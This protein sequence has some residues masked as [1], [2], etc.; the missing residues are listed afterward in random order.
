MD[1]EGGVQTLSRP[2]PD[3]LTAAW[4]ALGQA[5][6][7]VLST[8][9]VRGGPYALHQ[10]QGGG[11]GAAEMP[12]DPGGPAGAG[13]LSLVDSRLRVLK[14]QFHLVRALHASCPVEACVA[15]QRLVAET[16][17]TLALMTGSA[18][19]AQSAP[20]VQQAAASLGMP[21]R[22]ATE[23][24]AIW[25]QAHA[26]PRDVGVFLAEFETRT[27]APLLAR[28][29]D[30]PRVPGL[31]SEAP[32][33]LFRLVHAAEQEENPN[34]IRAPWLAAW[35]EDCVVDLKNR[36]RALNCLLRIQLKCDEDVLRYFL[37]GGQA[38]YTSL[39]QAD[40]GEQEWDT[41]I[42]INPSLSRQ[43]WDHA[44]AAV[45]DLVLRFLEQAR[46]ACA[47]M[48]RRYA[49]DQAAS[50]DARPAP[51]APPCQI[52]IQ[53][54]A[55]RSPE[56]SSQWA[57][58]EVVERQGLQHPDVPV[59]SLPYFVGELAHSLRGVLSGGQIS[60]RKTARRLLRLQAVLR[61]E[62]PLLLRHLGRMHDL[63]CDRLFYGSAA[64]GVGLEDAVARLR[65]WGLGGLL[66]SVPLRQRQADWLLAFDALLQAEAADLLE[67]AAIAPLWQQICDDIPPADRDCCRAL[68][69]TLNALHHLA[70]Q[71]AREEETISTALRVPGRGL[72][73]AM[74]LIFDQNA[75]RQE[76]MYYLTGTGAATL[77]TGGPL[78]GA[79]ADGSLEILYR[80]RSLA[81]PEAFEALADRLSGLLPSFGLSL[82]CD[83]EGLRIHADRP[84]RG[85]RLAV[86]RPVLLQISAETE[87][88]G[89]VER[90][91]GWPVAS[92]SDLQ[93][94]FRTR[95]A[96]SPDPEFRNR[97]CQSAEALAGLIAKDRRR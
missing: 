17:L 50:Q 51:D 89:A 76:G 37:K 73:Q 85:L 20:G 94:I 80:P 42:L 8:D 68:L 6:L 22:T 40:A 97:R 39:G 49:A 15:L 69:A 13:S 54:A 92:L 33:H 11:S 57:G 71:L 16:A 63:S 9:Y 59:P 25:A 41:G 62:D 72:R 32:F 35:H 66:A 83:D 34:A 77:Q 82:S 90:I 10:A 52:D 88:A 75:R 96:Q 91:N 38:L 64:F 46:Y 28:E 2:E 95:A 60:R 19:L 44:F 70:G 23:A 4:Q 67:E 3:R 78:P 79:G 86:T 48:A 74:D 21:A 29:K 30:A 43:S 14:S 36:L 18:T 7:A 45:N 31:C 84:L 12:V 27:L 26:D 61:S 47:G 5:P 58:L 93:R 65:A 53:I 87:R 56:L 24:A 81:A 55:H 1:G